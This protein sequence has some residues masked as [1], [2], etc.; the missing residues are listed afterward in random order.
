MASR[1]KVSST[2]YGAG[3][4]FVLM[5][6]VLILSQVAYRYFKKDQITAGPGRGDIRLQR[7]VLPDNVGSWSVTSFTEPGEGGI[8]G[9]IGWSHSWGMQNEQSAALV[10]FDQ[11]G[12]MGSWHELTECYEATGWTVIDRQIKNT[13]SS[14]T[15]APWYFVEA[16]MEKEGGQSAL[17]LYSIFN[18][19]GTSTEPP[20]L[21]PYVPSLYR[22]QE[23]RRC[24]QCQVFMPYAGEPRDQ[25]RQEVH[26][27]H[28]ATREIFRL[29]W[30]RQQAVNRRP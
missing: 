16:R 26:N 8:I 1:S 10:A 21:T 7:D 24:L 23:E 3:K 4:P 27:M 11:I 5:V 14:T 20:S 13:V 28:F 15:G 22:S 6:I 25:Q 29:E 30:R 19:E 18:G 17:L 12:L 9:R 2:Q